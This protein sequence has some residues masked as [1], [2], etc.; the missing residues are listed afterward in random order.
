M[1]DS[2]THNRLIASLSGREL[3]EPLTSHRRGQRFKSSTAHHFLLSLIWVVVNPVEYCPF[4][5]YTKILC[6]F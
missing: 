3:T 1:E 2:N 6:Y 5:T 4:R